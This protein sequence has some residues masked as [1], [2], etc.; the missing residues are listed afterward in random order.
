MA[1]GGLAERLHAGRPAHLLTADDVHVQVGNAVQGVLPDVEHQPIAAI[2]DP[3]RRGTRSSG[4]EHLGHDVAM[5]RGD[6]CGVGDVVSRDDEEV[7]RGSRIDVVEGVGAL[8]RQ[9]LFRRDLAGED[10]AEQA[11][12]HRLEATLGAVAEPDPPGGEPE[13]SP[14]EQSDSLAEA[15]FLAA[16]TNWAA[17]ERVAGEARSRSRLRSLNEAAA[18]SA[19]L[20]GILVDLAERAAEVQ[21][22]IGGNSAAAGQAGGES[23]PAGLGRVSGRLTG[24]GKDFC[25]LE[26]ANRRPAVIRT[27]ALTAVWPIQSRNDRTLSAR[28]ADRPRATTTVP[29]G[30][31]S[32]PLALSFIAV[33]DELTSEKAMVSIH[34]ASGRVSGEL[35]AVGQ[36]VVTLRLVD[37]GRPRRQVHLPA[38]AILYCELR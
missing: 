6:F 8:G 20:T 7:N 11:V 16:L 2:R 17:G 37:G 26:P 28:E 10:L 31:R 14:R 23:P 33:L 34:T 4:D 27:A 35:W 18:G 5:V 19:N 25:V 9:H 30:G 29:A 15:E 12:S 32:N 1:P 22:W 38:A 21:L 24:V 3:H 13:P 36:D